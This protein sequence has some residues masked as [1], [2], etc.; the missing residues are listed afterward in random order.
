MFYAVESLPYFIIFLKHS[1]KK[2]KA[3]L[4]ISTLITILLPRPPEN[5]AMHESGNVCEREMSLFRHHKTEEFDFILWEVADGRYTPSRV[6]EPMSPG[7]EGCGAADSLEEGPQGTRLGGQ[8]V[9]CWHWAERCRAAMLA[10]A[11]RRSRQGPP[12]GARL[13]DLCYHRCRL[14]EVKC[15]FIKP[16]PTFH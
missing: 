6:Q 8:A 11:E 15:V 10:A 4:S 12:T 3:I 9:E 2:K 5:D 16:L 7:S 14:C 13:P 1:F